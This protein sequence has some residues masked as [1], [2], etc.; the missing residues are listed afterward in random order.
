MNGQKKHFNFKNDSGSVTLFV[1]IAMIF[2]LIV[3]FFIYINSNNKKV[4]QMKELE[5]LKKNYESTAEEIESKYESITGD[6]TTN[7]DL[8]NFVTG[9]DVSHTHVYE[10][11]YDDTSHWEECFICGNV[12][13]KQEHHKTVSGTGSCGTYLV[14]YC[15]DG[16]GYSVSTYVYHEVELYDSDVVYDESGGNTNKNTYYHRLGKCKNCGSTTIPKTEDKNGQGSTQQCID[17][18]GKAITCSNRKKCVVCGYDWSKLE[19]ISHQVYSTQPNEEDG[20]TFSCVYC[21]KEVYRILYS[22]AEQDK[23]N[24]LHWTISGIYQL[25]GDIKWCI[26]ENLNT[27]SPVLDS[28]AFESL[29]YANVHDLPKEYYNNPQY[30][31]EGITSGLYLVQFEAYI[32]NGYQ[33]T[34]VVRMNSDNCFRYVNGNENEYGKTYAL[35]F[36]IS[37]D[38]QAPT[39]DNI[40]INK[41]EIINGFSKKATITVDCSDSYSDVVDIALYDTQGNCLVDYGTATNNG[42]K[43]F[44]RT[45]DIVAEATSSQTLVVKAKDRYN[46]ESTKNIEIQSLDAKAPTLITDED[47]TAEW[48]KN[49]KITFKA[50]DSGVGEVQIAFN[51]VDDYQ[52]AEK[53]GNVYTRTYNFYGDIYDKVTAAIYLKDAL[54]NEQMVKVDI[55]KLDNT[56]PTITKSELVG[57]KVILEAN[58][59]HETLGEGSGVAGYRYVTSSRD[60]NKRIMSGEGTFTETSEIDISNMND[61]KYLYIAPVDKVGNIGQ[62]V[63]IELPT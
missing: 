53:D 3:C 11:K 55:G 6:T 19:R 27:W 44:T 57:N 24:N 58:D 2:F 61:V 34:P 60:M 26:T 54:G 39:I 56:A 40:Q 52:L 59:M 7:V 49:K 35:N 1:L 8:T 37:P 12:Q 41:T 5:Q 16:C 28:G 38:T 22:N 48:S 20:K 32:K 10:K 42:N 18:D 45:F 4:S 50:T 29:E 51:N 25:V 15:T 17:E 46:N 23:D 33:G 9:E 30:G 43:T 14:E 47:Y 62:T 31:T 36:I 63:K 13:N 21:G